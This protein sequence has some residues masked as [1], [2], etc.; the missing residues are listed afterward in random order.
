MKEGN[1][2]LL[3]QLENLEKKQTQISCG[4]KLYWFSKSILFNTGT[5]RLYTRLVFKHTQKPEKIISN[6]R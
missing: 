3:M 4:H 5:S 2:T 1:R 6:V